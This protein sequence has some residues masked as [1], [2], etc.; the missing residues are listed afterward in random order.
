MPTSG[1]DPYGCDGGS[2]LNRTARGALRMARDNW[3]EIL[4]CPNCRKTGFAILSQTDELSWD[5]EADFV[6]TGFKVIHIKH[7]IIFH[8]A[9]CGF[10]VEP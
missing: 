6:P 7:G 8:C 4:K 1:S 9:S 5:M 3:V 2:G 10:P